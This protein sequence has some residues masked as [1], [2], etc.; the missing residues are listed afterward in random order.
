[1]SN[2]CRRLFGG[3]LF[4]ERK[5]SQSPRRRFPGLPFVLV[6]VAGFAIIVARSLTGPEGMGWETVGP[7]IGGGVMALFVVLLVVRERRERAD[8]KDEPQPPA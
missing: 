6:F 2:T 1:M 8:S 3:R 4:D 5:M 7:L